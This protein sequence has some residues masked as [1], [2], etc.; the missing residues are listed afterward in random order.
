MDPRTSSFATSFDGGLTW[1]TGT[2]PSTTQFALPPGPFDSVSDPSVAYDRAHGTWLIAALPVLFSHSG[3]PGVVVSRSQDG[4]TWSA[5][6]A[7]TPSNETT[8][9]KSWIACD[10]HASSPYF[11]HCYVEWDAAG[12]G[13][14][15]MSFSSDGGESWSAPS[16]P[17]AYDFGI[18]GQPV[19]QPN[20]TVV[21]PIDDSSASTVQ[22]FTSQDGGQT[23]SFLSE[24]SSIADHLE[25]GNL[26]SLPL[27]SAA[28]D[29]SGTVYVVWQ[30]CRFRAGCS[31]NDLVMST[32]TDGVAWTSPSRIPIDAVSSTVDHFIPG[33]SV[34]GGTS[35]AGAHL[36]LTYYS[37]PQANCTAATCQ[38]FADFISSNDGGRTWGAPKQLAG[39][40]MLNWLAQTA[41]GAM[42]GD[43]TASA[44]SSGRPVAFV[45]VADPSMG[46]KLDEAMYVPKAG[47]ITLASA[48]RRSSRGE[49]PVRG[50]HSDHPP[51][52]IHP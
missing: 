48:V 25:A 20:G 41:D 36:G 33:L 52:H 10:N 32:S 2:L 30:D 29:A 1:R 3:R 40:M 5:P 45:A 42:V 7:V 34:E 47:V 15:L 9:D 13:E 35:G 28:V 31:S 19:V 17:Q 4:L 24:V 51:R 46:G 43:Y 6:L 16:H 12:T 23:W 27:V 21:V 44:F 38:L 26:R 8:N 18:G 14:I 11:G 22:V 49:H 37:Y 50:F 39:P